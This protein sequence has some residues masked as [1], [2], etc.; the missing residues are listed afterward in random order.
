MD[1][2]GDDQGVPLK[3]GDLRRGAESGKK[4]GGQQVDRIPDALCRLT[5]PYS[6]ART[7]MATLPARPPL[8]PAEIG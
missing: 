2:R 7:A 8:T 3:R 6:I 1:H 5:I 4:P